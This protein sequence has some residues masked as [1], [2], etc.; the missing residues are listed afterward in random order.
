MSEPR[1]LHGWKVLLFRLPIWLY[2]LKL[3]WL[4]GGKFLLLHH[5]G[6][7]SGKPRQAVLE[8]VKYDSETDTY[9]IAAGFGAKSHWYQNLLHTP[10]V[11]IQVGSR[12]LRATAVPLGPQKSGEA[13][14]DYAR[15]N[16]NTARAL[17][18]FIGH[19]VDGSEETYQQLGKV[20]IPFIAL[21]PFQKN[22]YPYLR[23]GSF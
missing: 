7:K 22:N 17:C 12:R 16:P 3:G 21:R 14:V 18:R 2:R 4:L 1:K 6:R 13:M 8:V 9:F 20:A 15:R 23:G 10:N 5:I 19:S 11:I